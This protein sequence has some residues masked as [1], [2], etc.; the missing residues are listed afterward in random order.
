MKEYKYNIG[1][2]VFGLF[3]CIVIIISAIVFLISAV[4]NFNLRNAQYSFIALLVSWILWYLYP[5]FKIDDNFLYIKRTFLKPKPIPWQNI[6]SIWNFFGRT[7]VWVKTRFFFDNFYIEFT[8]N[9]YS[10]LVKEIKRRKEI[11][12]KQWLEEHKAKSINSIN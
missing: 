10:E 7:H 4:N 5:E 11:A 3:I 9:G 6:I 1:W 8:I 12:D 2:K